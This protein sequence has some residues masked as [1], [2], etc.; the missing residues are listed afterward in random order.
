MSII[1]R[2]MGSSASLVTSGFGPPPS[3]PPAAATTST[4]SED[5]IQ[6]YGGTSR[7]LYEDLA[8]SLWLDTYTIRARL[9]S[10]NGIQIKDSKEKVLRIEDDNR[11]SFS[12][13]VSENISVTKT[14]PEERILINALEVFKRK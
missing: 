5:F 7:P 13:K 2:G 14:K 1:T 9:V 6:R 12:A 11:S 3:A 8:K 10:V 4:T